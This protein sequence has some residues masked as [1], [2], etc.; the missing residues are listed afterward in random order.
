MILIRWD[1]KKQKSNIEKHDVAFDDAATL[2]SDEDAI[3]FFDVSHSTNEDR[4][5][6]IGKVLSGRVLMVVYSFRRSR[7]GKEIYYRIISARIAKKGEKQAY[8][9]RDT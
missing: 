7:D 5:L 2:F 1:D 3:E 4:F 8:Y 9:S 6:I